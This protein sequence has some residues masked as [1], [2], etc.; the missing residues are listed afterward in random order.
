M[1]EVERLRARVAELERERVKAERGAARVKEEKNSSLKKVKMEQSG[2]G[3][4]ASLSPREKK[5]KQE[6]IELN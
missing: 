4:A 2:S 5:G 6:V 1:T 3:N